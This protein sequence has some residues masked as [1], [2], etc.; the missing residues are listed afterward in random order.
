MLDRVAH[1]R[2]MGTPLA[3]VLHQAV[4]LRK[5]N[6]DRKIAIVGLILALLR[7]AGAHAD[8]Q[9]PRPVHRLEMPT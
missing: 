6:A 2:V 3:V 9:Q 7:W 1:V 8:L 5:E 4:P